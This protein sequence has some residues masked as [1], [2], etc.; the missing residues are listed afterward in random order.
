MEAIEVRFV[1]LEP[2]RVACASGFGA[3][4]EGEAWGKLMAWAQEHGQ[5]GREKSRRFFGFNNPDPHPGSPNYGYDQWMT[6]DP[7]VEG[8]QNVQILDFTGGRFAVTRCQL[9]HITEAWRNL[10]TWVEDSHH[11]MRNDQCLEECL[12]PEIVL[13]GING[14]EVDMMAGKFDLYL[15]IMD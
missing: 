1:H 10:V 3:S 14:A 9:S 6:V 4:P 11:Q 8:D 13:A 15:P 12:E 7:G 2:L 5:L